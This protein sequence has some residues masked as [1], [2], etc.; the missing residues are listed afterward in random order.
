MQKITTFLTFTG[1]AEE[2][3]LAACRV[4]REHVPS[5]VRG[6]HGGMTSNS[7]VDGGNLEVPVMEVVGERLV[8]PFQLAGGLTELDKTI[9]IEFAAAG[10]LGPW[11]CER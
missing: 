6:K 4:E 2:A 3:Q 8:I 5:F 1:Q 11:Y 7:R 10:R 9:G